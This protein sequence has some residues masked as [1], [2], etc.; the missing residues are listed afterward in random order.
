MAHFARINGDNTVVQIIVADQEFINSGAVGNPSEWL[1]YSY[2]TKG[3]IHYDPITNEPDGGI[4]FR[5]NPAGVGFRYDATRDAFIPPKPY[6]SWLLDEDTCLWNAPVEKPSDDK[7]YQWDEA[8]TS[9][10]EI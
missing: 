9:W 5:K 6:N 4:P 1:Q 3:G 10:I 2:N 7:K 8:T